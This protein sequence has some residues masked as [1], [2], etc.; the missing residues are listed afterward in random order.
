MRRPVLTGRISHS[1]A[2]AEQHLLRSPSLHGQDSGPAIKQLNVLPLFCNET[3]LS[4]L[5]GVGK[6]A[7]F[8]LYQW[9]LHEV[10][11]SSLTTCHYR[12]FTF[13][14]KDSL[15]SKNTE[16][17]LFGALLTDFFV[18]SPRCE[19]TLGKKHLNT[20]ACHLVP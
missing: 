2:D 18:C 7:V 4:K 10:S 3:G 6:K 8:F 11:L 12:N 17:L 19:I 14:K 9:Q 20:R 5:V 16:M 13:K 15:V 1:R